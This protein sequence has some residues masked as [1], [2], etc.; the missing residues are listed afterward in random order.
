MK[1]TKYYRPASRDY[2]KKRNEWLF[3]TAMVIFAVGMLASVSWL[4]ELYKYL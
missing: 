2:M 1:R 4:P 3:P